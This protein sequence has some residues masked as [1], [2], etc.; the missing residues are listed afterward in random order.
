V[1]NYQQSDSLSTVTDLPFSGTGYGIVEARA[2]DSDYTAWRWEVVLATVPGVSIPDR[3][4]VTGQSWLTIG[5]DGQGGAGAHLIWT[6]DWQTGTTSPGKSLQVYLNP[7]VYTPGS[8]WASFFDAPP[9]ALAGVSSGNYQGLPID[10]A[11]FT[12]SSSEI[13]TVTSWINS[14]ADQFDKMH[15]DATSGSIVG[16]QGNLANAV[17]DLLASLHTVM[18]G[19]HDQMTYPTSY[20]DS[21][22]A[23]GNSATTFLTDILSAHSSWAQLIE[24]SPLGAVVKVLE[25]IATLDA[26]GNYVIADPQNTPFGDLTVD[27]SWTAVEQQAKNLWTGTLTGSENFSGL[28]LLG[29]TALDKLVTQFS[30]TTN[31]IVPVTTPGKPPPPNSGNDNPN[32]NPNQVD[33]QT[34]DSGQNGPNNVFLSGGPGNQGP[35]NVPHPN[36]SADLALPGTGNPHNGQVDLSGGPGA[37]GPGLSHQANLTVTGGPGPMPVSLIATGPVGPA[38]NGTSGPA[39]ALG[40]VDNLA[41]SSGVTG[42]LPGTGATT[43]VGRGQLGFAEP[44]AG[45]TGFTGTIGSPGAGDLGTPERNSHARR[46]KKVLAPMQTAPSAG[47]SLGSDP[48]GAVL[49]RSAVPI[50]ATRPPAVTSGLVNLQPI[51]GQGGPAPALPSSPD[52][53]LGANAPAVGEMTPTVVTDGGVIGRGM[54][55]AGEPGGPGGLGA[56]GEGGLMPMGAGR[57]GGGLGRPERDRL[58]YLPEEAEYWGTKPE[59]AASSLQA[60]ARQASDEPDFEPGGSRLRAIGAEPEFTQA[61]HAITDRRKR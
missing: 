34:P 30:V 59:L 51:P 49:K 17:G 1:G 28:D 21:I 3:T 46:D 8:A 7:A 58:A 29:R 15:T 37:V 19:L 27:G 50:F 45:L 52:T 12:S 22:A 23:A 26:N 24:H 55:T 40:R 16:F 2:A 10:P 11:T 9:D 32:P 47:F 14:A 6:A 33:L 48:A 56:T 44:G 20:S 43:P 4:E 41:A 31:T 39:P 54:F 13:S 35:T 5:H 18:V 61:K 36:P 60:T 53:A 42:S 57:G 25:G 38:L